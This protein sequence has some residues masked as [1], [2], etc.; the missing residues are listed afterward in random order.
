MV[1]RNNYGSSRYLFH[2]AKAGVAAIQGDS[3]KVNKELDKSIEVLRRPPLSE[4]GD[5][6]SDLFDR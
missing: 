4:L 6:I 5:A 1:N 2:A 3:D